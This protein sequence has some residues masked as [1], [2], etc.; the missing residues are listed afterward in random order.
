MSDVVHRSMR[1][2]A[3]PRTGKV[4]DA[5]GG[6]SSIVH[7][8]S[9]GSSGGG[10]TMDME[11]C[12]GEGISIEKGQHAYEISHKDTS[13]AN[14]II[15]EKKKA[16][17]GI[18]LDDF[19][20]VTGLDT[21]DILDLEDLDKRYLR[22][23]INDIGSGFYTWEAGWMTKAPV[24]SAVYNIGWETETPAGWYV[25]ETGTAWYTSMNV[26]GPI[27]SNNVIGSPGYASGWTGFGSQWD[28]VNHRMETDY[29]SVRKELKVYALDVFRIYGTNGD[30]AVSTSNKIDR[31]EDTGGAWR[32]HI[33]D[34]DGEMYMNMRVGDVVRCQTWEKVSGR[35]YMARVTGI[36]EK[37]FE[38]SKT[39]L[40]GTATP[41][42]G[43][44]VIRWSSLTDND[45]KGL[46]YLSASDSYAP[47]MDVRFGDWD[48]TSGTI[49]VR[50]G[51]LDGINDPLFPELYGARD[52]FGLYT[53]NFYGVG[54]LILRQTGQSVHRTFEVLGESI[55]MGLNELREEVYVSPDGLLQNP[56]FLNGTTEFWE[57][58]NVIYP[59]TL[60]GDI[61]VANGNPLSEVVSG[62]QPVTDTLNGRTVLQVTG[63]TVRQRNANLNGHDP[64]KYAIKLSYR[65]VVPWGTM[66]AGME[67]SGLMVTVPLS[68]TG[69]WRRA[70]VAG[71]WDGTGDF[72]IRVTGGGIVNVVDISF[73]DDRLTNVISQVRVEYDTR[74]SLKADNATLSS[75][76]KEY[77]E[78]NRVVRE[79]YATQSWTATKISTEVGAIV[80]GKLVG[81]STI[82]QTAT[83]ISNK[84]E[85][86]DL[87]Q[88]ATTTWT[89]NQ[90]ENRV[91]DL[92]LGQYATTTWTSGR[93]SSAVSGKV[94]ESEVRSIVEQ[95]YE[96]MLIA[97]YDSLSEATDIT[98]GF[99]RFDNTRMSL[100]RRMEV[101]SGSPTSFGC[102]A[103]MSPNTDNVAF[104]AGG[105][106][107]QAVAGTAKTIIYH[108]GAG[109]F[110]G[111][112]E[113]NA[114][115]DRIIIDP[116]G[117]CIKMLSG[118]V[119]VYNL[120]FFKNASYTGP[121]MT[122]TTATRT[123][124]I[125]TQ[126]EI[127][128]DGIDIRNS[129]GT[130]FF[131]ADAFQKKIW[132]DYSSLPQGRDN[133]YS[134]EIYIDGEY[135]KV[136]KG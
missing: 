70:E 91:E 28:M 43:D 36:D 5:I 9:S 79:D 76:R 123:G 63:T 109:K 85:S 12:E 52:N 46:L 39:L 81:Y 128:G 112:I 60:G 121:R 4:L 113:S 127:S 57:F 3:L 50:N 31:V 122:L 90:I 80:D 71:D 114:D 58:E 124:G 105:T 92:N 56:S 104:W 75:F 45:R 97:F 6:V 118:N 117:R 83:M 115:G 18:D 10:G 119:E 96:E 108:D 106:Y 61:L 86:L 131:I 95:T 26:R 40:D 37:W 48:A 99:Y 30:L 41:A 77:D 55:T 126:T 14:S 69:K 135:V 100:N 107:N 17:A 134:R 72:V 16:L 132:I 103:G 42:P 94:G 24:R 87:G 74:L 35:Y 20:H 29:I 15:K 82:V 38:L 2:K 34:Y 98:G 62:A 49:K 64:G 66:T 19:G 33:D 25:S 8:P 23:D 1:K 32:C 93:I 89:R 111:R 78:F 47:Y 129:N 133:A 116:S 21:C 54:D 7:A 130:G 22:K 53:S 65:P 59:F 88:Y 84:V 67:G 102:Q 68:D 44:I 51:R 110:T 125:N 27:L 120:D 13:T 101:G 73:A 11:L 136:R